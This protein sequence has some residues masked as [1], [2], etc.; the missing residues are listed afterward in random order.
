MFGK[1]FIVTLACFASIYVAVAFSAECWSSKACMDI[2]V[3]SD[4]G[5]LSQAGLCSGSNNIQCC[6]W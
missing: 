2:G 4:K 1:N 5:G 3:C 6:S